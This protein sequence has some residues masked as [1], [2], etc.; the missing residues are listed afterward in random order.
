MLC[1]LLYGLSICYPIFIEHQIEQNKNTP[2]KISLLPFVKTGQAFGWLLL[3]VL[4]PLLFNPWGQQ[5]FELPKVVWMR[6][7]VWLLAGLALAECILYDRSLWRRLRK[8]PMLGSTA[9]LALVIVVTTITAVNWRLSLWGSTER[10]QG[11]VTLLTYLLLFLLAAVHFQSVEQARQMVGV[12]A[13]TGAPLILLSL[14]QFIGWQPFALTSDARSAIYATLGR[15]NFLGAYMAVLVPLTLYLLLTTVQRK[16]RLFWA[17]L[18]FGDLLVLGLTLARSAWLATAVSL[19]LFALLWWGKRL[20]RSGQI[21][22]WSSLGLLVLS[23]PLTVWWG[24]NQAGSIAARLTIWRGTLTLI[25]QRPLLGYGSEALGV[26]FPGVYPPELV[27]YQGRDFFVDRAHNLF[28]DWAAAAGIPGLMA[29]SLVLFTFV[30][31]MRRT[32]QQPQPPAKRVLMAAL[33]AAVLAA[34]VNNLTSFDVTPTAMSFWLLLG[35]AVGLSQPLPD[36]TVIV[37]GKRPFQHWLLVGGLFIG[38]TF[39]VWQING[40][41]L[42]AD[43]AAQSAQ[44]YV[45]QGDVANAIVAAEEAVRYWP[46]EPTHHLRLSQAYW[47]QAITNS[48]AAS[49]WLPK[50]E[51]ALLMAQQLRPEDP[52]YWLHTAQFY[53]LAARQFDSDTRHL[54]DVAYQQ[55]TALAPNHATIYAAWGQFKIEAGDMETAVSLLRQAATLDASNGETYLALGTAELVLGHLDAALGDYREAV[56]LL[57]E[58]SRAYT[59]LAHC[60]WQL[61]QPQEAMQAAT[62]ALKRDPN[63]RQAIAIQQAAKVLP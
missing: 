42:L 24:H 14:T 63:N 51:T 25:K 55:A 6:T 34:T 44:R 30:I 53:M 8:N 23:G 13:A 19:A 29:Y 5:P 40:R 43:R 27:Y 61:A 18:L 12:L 32:W 60:Y 37:V 45:Q 58:S 47:Q 2:N 21:L 22:A 62:E 59:G 31:L 11:T 20:S 41:P 56:R 48:A 15:A 50:A 36:Q 7:L 46:S 52:A 39:I 57:P 9:A 38:I 49:I 26:V 4:T 10:M 16:L 54:A 35:M 3:I 17:V 33:M 1:D 28:L